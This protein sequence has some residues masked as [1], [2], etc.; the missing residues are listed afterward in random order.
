MQAVEL[1][2]IQDSLLLTIFLFAYY[3]SLSLTVKKV[4]ERNSRGGTAFAKQFYGSAQSSE[5]GTFG[6][7]CTILSIIR[8][9]KSFRHLPARLFLK[10]HSLCHCFTKIVCSLRYAPNPIKF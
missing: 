8:S 7:K 9:L 5:L 3:L 10:Q 2:I 4:T 6:G 1:P